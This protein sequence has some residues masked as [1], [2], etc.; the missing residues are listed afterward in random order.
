MRYT[1]IITIFFLLLPA[2]VFAWPGRIVAVIDG[3]TITVEPIEG[4]QPVR[5]RLHGIDAPEKRQPGGESARGF[6][7]DFLYK[8]V[9]VEEQKR[10]PDRY[11][12]AVAIIHLSNG[13]TLQAALLRAGFAWVWPRYCENCQSWQE[14]QDD[15]RRAW[16]GLWLDPSPTAPWEWRQQKRDARERP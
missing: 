13:D 5:V 2:P 15:A 4:G 7:F 9:E 16:R 10:S 6:V 14:L 12:R 1:F 3:D 11:G 8:S